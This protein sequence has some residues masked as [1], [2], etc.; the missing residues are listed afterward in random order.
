[1]TCALPIVS[2]MCL[3]SCYGRKL[4][5]PPG[6]GECT[7]C[8]WN[9]TAKAHIRHVY[10]KLDIHTREELFALVEE[11]RIQKKSLSIA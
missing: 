7:T 6:K 2:I 3:N 4:V 1:M 5:M 11:V 10:Q 9:G 8:E